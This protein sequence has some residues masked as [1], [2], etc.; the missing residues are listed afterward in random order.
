M[1]KCLTKLLLNV[2]ITIQTIKREITAIQK[3]EAKMEEDVVNRLREVL[4][5]TAAFYV[6]LF[7]REKREKNTSSKTTNLRLLCVRYDLFT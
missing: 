5:T 3:K 6:K 4:A 2:S 1:N 7:I